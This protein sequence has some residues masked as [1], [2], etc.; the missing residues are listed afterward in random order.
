MKGSR[1]E[2]IENERKE[3]KE[4][5]EQGWKKTSIFRNCF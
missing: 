3:Y 2:S 1:V 4:I 5:L